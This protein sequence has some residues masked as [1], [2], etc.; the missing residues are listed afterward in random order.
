MKNQDMTTLVFYHILIK[1]NIMKPG[2]KE[3]TLS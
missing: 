1:T 2:D 3:I